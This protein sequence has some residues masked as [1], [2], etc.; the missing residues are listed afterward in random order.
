MSPEQIR[1]AR[2][3]DGRSDIWALGCILYTL[4]SGHPPFNAP[5][6][7]GT[8]AKIIADPVPPL[9]A[10]RPDVPAELEAIILL[11]LAKS[12]E[13]RFQHVEHLA[14]SLSGF[15][16]LSRTGVAAPR[17]PPAAA[18]AADVD[19][20]T[21]IALPTE[22]AVTSVTSSA[23]VGPSR[24][25]RSALL[26]AAL[27]ALLTFV[28]AVGLVIALVAGPHRAAAG[29]GS[30]AAPAPVPPAVPSP[31]NPAPSAL[32]SSSPAPAAQPPAPPS[33]SGAR[34]ALAAPSS[35]EPRRAAAPPPAPARSVAPVPIYGQD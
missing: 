22:T 16:E 10:A 9:R 34:P 30:A 8:L 14:S 27:G 25:P 33:S 31:G 17:D 11:C 13:Q 18:P 12:P 24:A 15:Q 35:R 5:T 19:P 28:V 26:P 6:S 3:V 2:F 4:L 1:D 21:L 7:S 29:A 23:V 20:A 32:P